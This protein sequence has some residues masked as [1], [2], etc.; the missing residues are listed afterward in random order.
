MYRHVMRCWQDKND[1]ALT[2]WVALSSCVSPSANNRNLKV[3]PK[4][5]YKL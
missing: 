5:V 4:V 2:L 3:V 1:N